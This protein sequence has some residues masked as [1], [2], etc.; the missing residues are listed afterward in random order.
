MSLMDKIPK[1]PRLEKFCFMFDLYL[2][3]KY[4]SYLLI[5][6]WAI[7]AIGVIVD[8][9]GGN[10]IWGIIWTLINIGGFLGVVYGMNKNNR[11]YLVP[12]LILCV[13]AVVE[14]H[15]QLGR[16][17]VPLW[18]RVPCVLRRAQAVLPK[19]GH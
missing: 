4:T 1:P 17:P 12:A 6:L 7:Y 9:G 3:V 13:L 5:I 18:Q 14:A 8:I 15:G 10:M 16:R 19:A 2:S 11:T